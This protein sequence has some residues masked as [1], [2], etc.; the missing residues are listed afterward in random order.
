MKKSS[1]Q[2]KLTKKE[3]LDPKNW[4]TME[5]VFTP[6]EMK[7]AKRAVEKVRKEK[8]VKLPKNFGKMKSTQ[9]SSKS[10]QKN[11]NLPKDWLLVP[12]PRGWRIG[13]TVENFMQWVRREYGNDLFY[14]PDDDLRE[15]YSE[16]L[17][18]RTK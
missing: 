7:K 3:I 16:F 14:Y 2:K 1:I 15:L 9:R 6:A 8:S 13:Q 5:E 17:K 11:T 18:K 10:T 12:R 4:V